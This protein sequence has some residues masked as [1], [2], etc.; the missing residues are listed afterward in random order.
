MTTKRA[1]A[2]ALAVA[3]LLGSAVVLRA[4]RFF[5]PV[6]ESSL[7]HNVPYDGRFTFARI[8]YTTGPGGYYYRGLPAWAHGYPRAERDL[9][10]IMNEVSNIAPR[11]DASNVIALDDPALEKYPVA[12]MTEGGFW[13][14]TD[15]EAAAMR[16]YL[17][18]GGFVIF[19]DFRDDG[20]RGGGGWEN[21]AAN[22]RR[23]LPEGRFVDLST[24]HPIFH[25]FFEI[26]SFDIVQQYYDRGRPVFRGIFED[27]DPNKRL[28]V[29]VNFNTDVSNFW[30]FSA[31]GE[32][33][34]SASN[35]AYKLGV[36]YL[37]YG[38]TH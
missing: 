38:M 11:L 19:D 2:A 18:K 1:I 17:Q 25:S 13:T 26:D 32:V 20:F 4:Q 15:K 31:T 14:M 23:V 12:Y 8:R 37:I 21:F 36:N 29:M 6:D 16:A 33:P 30:E 22:M 28:L 3:G 27:N 10:Q 9:M 34:V 7:I 24:S 5:E 35:E